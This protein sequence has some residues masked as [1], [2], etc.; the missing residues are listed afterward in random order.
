MTRTQTESEERIA[1]RLKNKDGS[2][3]EPKDLVRLLKFQ[4]I[5]LGQEDPFAQIFAIMPQLNWPG[6][7][8]L[9][10]AGGQPSYELAIQ[11]P[12]GV[13]LH[14]TVTRLEERFLTVIV[15][16]DP[17]RM[18]SL[19][20]EKHSNGFEWEGTPSFHKLF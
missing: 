4:G 8:K 11:M 14:M 19:F 7:W 12:A 3:I 15:V 16:Q 20:A 5:E 9:S 2:G 10:R 18:T 13:E 17:T 1:V 6:A